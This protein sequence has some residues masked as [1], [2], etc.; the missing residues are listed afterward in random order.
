VARTK[1]K[2]KPRQKLSQR[3]RHFYR[4]GRRWEAGLLTGA[5]VAVC[6]IVPLVI[7]AV[8]DN[9]LLRAIGTAMVNTI[10][11]F[12][13][14]FY[15]ARGDRWFK[16]RFYEGYEEGTRYGIRLGQ[17]APTAMLWPRQDDNTFAIAGIVTDREESVRLDIVM[18]EEAKRHNLPFTD[19]ST[20]G[21]L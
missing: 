6:G 12:L 2:K 9:D 10:W 17:A 3:L 7:A 1:G 14:L 11:V 13:G 20:E 4:K 16:E 21:P 18:A 15:S 19:S 5:A 8:N